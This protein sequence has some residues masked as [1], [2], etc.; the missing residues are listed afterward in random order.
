MKDWIEHFRTSAVG[1]PV[2]HVCRGHGSAIFIELG[3]LKPTKRRD[4]SPGEPE[5]E[6]GLMIEWSWRMEDARSILCGSW[7]NEALWASSFSLLAGQSVVD[8]ATFGRLPEVMLS[9]SGNLHISSF[10][11]AEGDP[12]WTLFDRRGSSNIAVGCRSGVIAKDE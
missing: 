10:M 11:T 2:A 6:I 3:R 5:G 12:Q 8:L 4:G 7:S 1:L 9:F